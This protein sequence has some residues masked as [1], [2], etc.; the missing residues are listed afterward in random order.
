MEQQQRARIDE[1]EELLAAAVDA[2]KRK[3]GHQAVLPGRLPGSVGLALVNM[4]NRCV[5]C[6]VGVVC[7]A[8]GAMKAGWMLHCCSVINLITVLEDSRW[9]CV[10]SVGDIECC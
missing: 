3:Q 6:C 4:R 5:G 9:T 1:E 2:D 10:L 8:L 7:R